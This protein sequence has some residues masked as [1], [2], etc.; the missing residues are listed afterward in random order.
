MICLLS[1]VVSH[2]YRTVDMGVRVQR[3]A[4]REKNRIDPS[5]PHPWC[6]RV[7]AFSLDTRILIAFFQPNEIELAAMHSLLDTHILD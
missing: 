3:R 1:L 5:R 7:H 2:T 6:Q 4:K